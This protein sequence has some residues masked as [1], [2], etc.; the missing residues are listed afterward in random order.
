MGQWFVKFA[1]DAQKSVLALGNQKGTPFLWDIDSEDPS[2]MKP[3]ILYNP[4]CTSCI[5]Q[6]SFSRDGNLLICVCDDG[7]IWRWERATATLIKIK[8]RLEP[9]QWQNKKKLLVIMV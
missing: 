3:T 2:L 7:S 4:R 9:V 6:T 1:I 5:R 8:R